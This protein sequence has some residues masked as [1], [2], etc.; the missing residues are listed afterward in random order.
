MIPFRQIR[1]MQPEEFVRLL[2][3]DLQAAGVVAGCNYRFG[4]CP[5]QCCGGLAALAA[6]HMQF[7]ARALW[8]GAGPA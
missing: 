1:G 4:A 2:A 7:W 6:W 3:E 5:S 8:Q